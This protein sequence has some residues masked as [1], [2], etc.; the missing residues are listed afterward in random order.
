MRSYIPYVGACVGAIAGA[1]LLYVVGLGDFRNGACGAGAAYGALAGFLL[2][3]DQPRRWLVS[4]FVVG[5]LIGYLLPTADVEHRD[6]FREKHDRIV[7]VL[8][9]TLLG[10]LLGATIEICRS[11]LRWGRI[12]HLSRVTLLLLVAV[13]VVLCANICIYFL[14]RNATP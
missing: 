1:V 4:G 10:G 8:S 7:N 9:L 2:C 11:P 3:R 12:R 6:I 13:A 5:A 14:I